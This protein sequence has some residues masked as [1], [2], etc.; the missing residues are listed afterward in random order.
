MRKYVSYISSGIPDVLGRTV[1]GL[2]FLSLIS[3]STIS[4]TLAQADQCQEDHLQFIITDEQN[5]KS[6]AIKFGSEEFAASIYAANINDVYNPLRLFPGQ[7]LKIPYNV[8]HFNEQEHSVEMVLANPFC[9]PEP[10]VQD[11]DELTEEEAL[12]A[13]REAFGALVEGEEELDEVQEEA[14]RQGERQILTEIDGMIHDET[15]SKIGR[16]FYDIFYTRWQTP[17]EAA[18]YTI[19]ITE[20]PAPSLGTFISVEV[21]NNQTFR[22]RLQPRYDFIEEAANLAIRQT[23]NHMEQGHHTFRIY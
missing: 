12:E 23:R 8:Y 15:R 6:V 14:Q 4:A 9:K 13:F 2:F 21:N 5:I 16:D 11:L 20:Q 19:R 1:K 18:N 22:M 3:F 17:A 7:T 10:I